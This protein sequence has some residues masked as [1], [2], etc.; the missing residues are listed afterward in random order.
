MEFGEWEK[1]PE[2]PDRYVRKFLGF[3]KHKGA[4]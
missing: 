3:K 2:N 1:D 4:G